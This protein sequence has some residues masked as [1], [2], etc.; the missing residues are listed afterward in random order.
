LPPPTLNGILEVPMHSRQEQDEA[1]QLSGTSIRDKRANPVPE[2]PTRVGS[3]IPR[4]NVY[5]KNVIE[6]ETEVKASHM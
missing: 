6:F 4:K 1:A 3:G 2:A 5:N